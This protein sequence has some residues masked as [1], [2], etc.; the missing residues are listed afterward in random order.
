MVDSAATVYCYHDHK[1]SDKVVNM[2]FCRYKKPISLSTNNQ[3]N[4][5]DYPTSS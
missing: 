5:I 4:G 1:N 3:M 2:H